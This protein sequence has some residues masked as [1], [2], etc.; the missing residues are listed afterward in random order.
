MVDT[1]NIAILKDNKRQIEGC[2]RKIQ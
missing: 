2:I 1:A